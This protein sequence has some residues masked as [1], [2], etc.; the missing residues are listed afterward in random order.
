MTVGGSNGHQ[1]TEI[2]AEPTSADEKAGDL[3]SPAD[4]ARVLSLPSSWRA[5]L[6]QL[7]ILARWFGMWAETASGLAPC[8]VISPG[9]GKVSNLR[10]QMA[11]SL[12]FIRPDHGFLVGW[13]RKVLYLAKF[14]FGTPWLELPL[15]EL[16]SRS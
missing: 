16:R 14:E 11:P 3:L 7:S 9:L 8:T 4:D 13:R 5:R 10:L 12:I 6:L 2:G 1:G 15:Q